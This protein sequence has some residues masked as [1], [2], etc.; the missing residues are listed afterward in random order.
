M[1]EEVEGITVYGSDMAWEWLTDEMRVSVDAGPDGDSP[2]PSIQQ[3]SPLIEA[4]IEVPYPPQVSPMDG[5]TVASP[6]ALDELRVGVYEAM[7]RELVDEHGNGS[8]IIIRAKLCSYLGGGGCS[9]QIR[10]SEQEALAER[11][12]DLGPVQ[13][14]D[15]LDSG[16]GGARSITLLGP[17]RETP[18]GLRVEGG[19]LCGPLCAGGDMYIVE[20]VD[21]GYR[22]VGKD[23][24]YGSWIS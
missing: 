22:V 11:L 9:G 16:E 5:N 19:Y 1:R 24:T 21:S 4:S 17:I 7:I 6:T 2:F 20:Q 13:F 12:G 10:Q 23:L 3:L 18:D 14:V 8:R 15:G